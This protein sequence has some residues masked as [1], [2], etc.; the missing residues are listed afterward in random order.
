MRKQTKKSCYIHIGAPKTG[1]TCLQKFFFENQDALLRNDVLYPRVSLRGYGHHDIAFLLSGGYPDWASPQEKTLEQLIGQ[2]NEVTL[3]HEGDILLSSENFYL[4][5][6]PEKLLDVLHSTNILN[7]REAKIIVYVRRQ[8]EAHESW[9]NQTVKAQGYTHS[10][11]ACLDDFFDLWDYK[12]QL[13]L[14]ASIFGDENIIVR[15]Y[16][17]EQLTGG[18]LILDFLEAANI[19]ASGF[20]IPEELVNSGINKDLLEFQRIINVLPLSPED[21]RMF[22]KDLILLSADT[23]GLG[24]FD[25]SPMLDHEA[26]KTI[27]SK[28]TQG[29]NFVA[30]RYVQKSEL[31]EG[32]KDN[33]SHGISNGKG[34]TTDKLVMILGWLIIR[35]NINFSMNIDDHE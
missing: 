17:E 30:K 22:H 32:T 8:D 25:E 1:T 35:N 3:T 15:P 31:F 7:Q 4:Y 20:S 9:Y 34:L 21:K 27:M 6:H 26:R 16:V 5:P 14:W 18:N 24:F 2:L 12:G 33:D 29:N 28:Y 19:E 11:D 10:I 13:D 23:S